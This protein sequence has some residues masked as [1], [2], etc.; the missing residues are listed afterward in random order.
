MRT[1]KFI[2]IFTISLFLTFGS[3]VAQEVVF[4]DD[5]QPT[6]ATAINGLEVGGVTYDVV[7]QL[8]MFASEIYGAYPGTFSIFDTS[9]EAQA[10]VTAINTAL[11]GAGARTIGNL[12][13]PDIESPIYNI[14]YSSLILLEVEFVNVWRGATENDDDWKTRQA[15]SV[16]R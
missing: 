5:L 11:K 12:D 6:M 3:T 7:F 10:A 8:S 4:G 9:D 13:Q 1:L 2:S 15:F 16:S 14:G